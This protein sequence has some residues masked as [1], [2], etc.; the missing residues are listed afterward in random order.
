M[1]APHTENFSK[2]LKH[3]T[4]YIWRELFFHVYSITHTLLLVCY[5]FEMYEVIHENYRY[6]F[7][8][9]QQRRR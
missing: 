9:Q 5:V 3:A 8:L 2:S 6:P 4:S 1:N 7:V